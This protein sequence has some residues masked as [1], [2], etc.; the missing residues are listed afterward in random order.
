MYLQTLPNKS[1]KQKE[2]RFSDNDKNKRDDEHS[3]RMKERK[4]ANYN[5]YSISS[6][7]NHLTS[8]FV[9][10]TFTCFIN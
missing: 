10:L 7:I 1:T 4:T 8:L 6:R 3:L 2:K 5:V 9:C